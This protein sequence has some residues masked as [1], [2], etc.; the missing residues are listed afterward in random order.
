MNIEQVLVE[1]E[2][3]I[4]Q[5][6]SLMKPDLSPER[7]WLKYAEIRE[8][9]LS[10]EYHDLSGYSVIVTCEPTL[11]LKVSLGLDLVMGSQVISYG[12]P[13]EILQMVTCAVGTLEN[14]R[15]QKS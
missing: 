15:E 2:V 11:A 4:C 1:L 7:H 6:I 3:P 14:N 10:V 13:D 8:V 5:L 9:K 12:D